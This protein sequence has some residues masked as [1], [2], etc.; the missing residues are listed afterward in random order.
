MVP[1][2]GRGGDPGGQRSRLGDALFEDLPVSRF[3]VEEETVLV[4]GLVKL[5]AVGI[6]SDGP[7]ERLHSEGARFSGHNGHDARS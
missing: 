2:R 3:L 6:D 5:S 4:C 1:V 7:E